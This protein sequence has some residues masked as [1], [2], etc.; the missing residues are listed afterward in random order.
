MR[1]HLV[2][3]AVVLVLVQEL[4]AFDLRLVK[5]LG[6]QKRPHLATQQQRADKVGSTASW[7]P[8]H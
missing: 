4:A 7:F 5:A 8:C 3:G 1:A 2:E 6:L